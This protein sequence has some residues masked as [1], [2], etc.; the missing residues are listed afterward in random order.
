MGLIS[1]TNQSNFRVDTKFLEKGIS[2]RTLCLLQESFSSLAGTSIGRQKIQHFLPQSNRRIKRGETEEKASYFLLSER[3]SSLFCKIT[4]KV[5]SLHEHVLVA[6]NNFPP[7]P[8]NPVSSWTGS[9]PN[10]DQIWTKSEPNL[11]QIWTKSGIE[12]KPSGPISATTCNHP[13]CRS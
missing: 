4:R 3:K 9:G 13:V 8:P 7:F 10:L 11:D 12:Q 5:L 1:L 2:F 6:H